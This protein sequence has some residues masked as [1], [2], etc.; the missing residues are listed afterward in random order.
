MIDTLYVD[1]DNNTIWYEDNAN[2]SSNF[3]DNQ[4]IN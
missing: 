4:V 3:K 2:P 1:N